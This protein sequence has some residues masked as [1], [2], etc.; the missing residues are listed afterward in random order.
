MRKHK[1][2]LLLAIPLVI[3][4]C[5]CAQGMVDA[6]GAQAASAGLGAG[7]AVS[8]GHGKVVQRAGQ[9][10]SAS[11]QNFVIQT[12]AIQQYMAV[13]AQ[14]ETKKQWANAEKSYQYVLKVVALRDGPGSIYGLP[15]LQHLVSVSRAASN[16]DQAVGYQDTVVR[17]AKAAKIPDCKTILNAQMLLADLLV[18]KQDFPSA[19]VILGESISFCNENPAVPPQHRKAAYRAYGK[20]LRKL[21]KDA[22]ADEIEKIAEQ[23]DASTPASETSARPTVNSDSKTSEGIQQKPQ[24]GTEKIPTP[25]PKTG[26]VVDG[27]ARPPRESTLSGVKTDP[28]QNR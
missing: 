7:L 15:A 1:T 4:Q 6:G 3:P 21:H 14:Y 20:V 9:S 24:P 25:E 28:G 27:A 2:L 26:T 16:F 19:E 11:Q 8:A 17:F 10:L 23:S 18:Q 5:A 13:G 22:R 12:R